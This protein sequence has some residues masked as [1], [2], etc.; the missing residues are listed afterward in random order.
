MLRHWSNH[1]RHQG[2]EGGQKA[3]NAYDETGEEYS[4]HKKRETGPWGGVKGKNDKLFLPRENGLH[5]SLKKS[6]NTGN[7]HCLVRGKKRKRRGN[8]QKIDF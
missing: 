3:L 7:S 2:L 4:T 5:V 6:G 8:T 1:Q